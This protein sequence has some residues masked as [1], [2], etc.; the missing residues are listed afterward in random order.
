MPKPK[1]T[2][3]K[4]AR[5]KPKPAS[6]RTAR[7]SGDQPVSLDAAIGL[8]TTTPLFKD[9]DAAERGDVARIIEMQR[10]QD[11]EH[12]FREGDDGDAWYVIFKGEAKVVK[13]MRAGATPTEIAVLGPGACFGEMAILD[14]LT[15]SASVVANG[16]LTIFRLRRE[17]FESLLDEG[18]LGAYKL[19]AAMARS[20]SQRQRRLTQRLSGLLN[21][22]S[23]RRD[24]VQSYHVSE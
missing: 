13:R 3:N 21:E 19:V 4:V 24:S 23:A 9:L 7:R 12:V 15:R 11:A 1:K 18:N 6:R 20:L 8:L 14:G 16:P 17:R 22:S 2:G 5:E 10:L